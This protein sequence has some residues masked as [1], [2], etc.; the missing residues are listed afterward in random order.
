MATSAFLEQIEQKIYLLQNQGKLSEAY[1][2][3]KLY[4]S[5]YPEEKSLHSLK[6][7]IEEA[8]EDANNHL[9]DKKLA[10]LSP[11]WK[12]GNY[13]KIIKE[14]KALLQYSPNHKE[15]RKQYQT[16]QIKYKE[17]IEIR[18]AKYEKQQIAK[19]DKLLAENEN[20]LVGELYLLSNDNPNNPEVK[21][22]V[23]TYRNKVI[24]KKLA[25]KRELMESEKFDDIANYLSQLE[26]IDENS[27]IIKRE[28]DNLQIRKHKKQNQEKQEF[29]Y[30]GMSHL[31]TLMKLGK[32]DKAIKVAV[33][34]LETDQTNKIA[35]KILKSAEEK[36]FEQ[37]RE[38]TIQ[39]ITEGKSE[40]QAD[41]KLHQDQYISI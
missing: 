13:P 28:R 27:P 20:S 14:L 22:L 35:K 16:A 36:L 33:E 37:T 5:Q 23:Q 17:E 11:S 4:L 12:E 40:I 29:V 26:K 19:F 31:D 6:G 25:Q 2:L 39:K 41:T 18:S 7:E 15:L 21:N 3:C 24:E 34:I 32:Y 38:I 1:D 30:Q 8:I 9:V 10:E